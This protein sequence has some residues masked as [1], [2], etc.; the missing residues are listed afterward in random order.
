MQQND[1][2]LRS[3]N[4]ISSE[5]KWSR[6]ILHPKN[7]FM[8]SSFFILFSQKGFIRHGECFRKLRS[9]FRF[10]TVEMTN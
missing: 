8:N 10:A 5:M 2:R 7:L 3:I 9:P 4:V 1:K 6:E